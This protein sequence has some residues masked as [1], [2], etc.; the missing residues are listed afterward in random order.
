MKRETSGTGR[1][2]N[3][4]VN[5]NRIPST[6][7]LQMIPKS[8]P[9]NHKKAD[10]VNHNTDEDIHDIDQRDKM[11]LMMEIDR[12]NQQLAGMKKVSIS[13]SC[14]NHFL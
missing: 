4:K 9:I 5:A 14:S 1:R 12:L 13:Y 10:Y 8:N 6:N 7:G 3:S 2:P 11:D